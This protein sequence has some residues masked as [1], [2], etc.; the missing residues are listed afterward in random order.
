MPYTFDAI[1]MCI[2]LA[3]THLMPHV[4]CHTLGAI[5]IWCHAHTSTTLPCTLAYAGVCGTHD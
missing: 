4:W 5:H 3:P 2:D 1:R